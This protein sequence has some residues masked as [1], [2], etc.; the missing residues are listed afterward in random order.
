MPAPAPLRSNGGSW[1]RDHARTP[2][3]H[4]RWLQA[5]AIRLVAELAQDLAAGSE[6]CF[7]RNAAAHGQLLFH[8]GS[9]ARRTGLEH[10]R[11]YALVRAGE[12]SD[13]IRGTDGQRRY[14]E[15][16]ERSVE[17]RRLR[18]QRGKRAPV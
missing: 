7:P 12:V 4:V 18:H 14:R 11:S 13:E 10:V 6:E 8:F 3:A 16:V 15:Q 9:Q 17:K 2:R 1:R 5:A